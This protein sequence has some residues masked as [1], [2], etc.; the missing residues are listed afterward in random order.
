MN[1]SIPKIKLNIE[2]VQKLKLIIP[3]NKTDPGQKQAKL[4]VWDLNESFLTSII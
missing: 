3:A 2:S 4:N 1:S